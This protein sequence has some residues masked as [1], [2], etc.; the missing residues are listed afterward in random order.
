MKKNFLWMLVTILFCG[1]TT[2][3]MSSCGDDDNDNGKDS[4]GSTTSTAVG[5]KVKY[6]VKV[7]SQSTLDACNVTVEYTDANGKT[8]SQALTTLDE[9]SPDPITIKGL[10]NKAEMTLTFAPKDNL[11]AEKYDVEA[12]YG[13]GAV[14]VDAQGKEIGAIG[15][16][17]EVI[18]NKGIRTEAKRTITRTQSATISANGVVEVN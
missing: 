8:K 12:T 6:Y 3:S 10:P 17:P 1:L 5:M 18:I 7:A 11:T 2:I 13:I 16:T 14:A 4:G 9:F 15:L